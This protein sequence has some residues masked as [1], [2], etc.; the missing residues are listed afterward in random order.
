MYIYNIY[1][2]QGVQRLPNTMFPSQSP[3]KFCVSS[4]VECVSLSWYNKFIV[5]RKGQKDLK[6]GY[7]GL[8]ELFVLLTRMSWNIRSSPYQLENISIWLFFSFSGWEILFQ[9][10][11]KSWW[12]WKWRDK[13]KMWVVVVRDFGCM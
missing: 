12:L 6:T 9:F 4:I 11:V 8:V 5:S 3:C 10:Y 2:I 13:I 1:N 7:F